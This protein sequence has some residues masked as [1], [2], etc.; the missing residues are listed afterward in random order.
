MDTAAPRIFAML[1][2]ATSMHLKA[3]EREEPFG[4]QMSTGD[5]RT[6]I[7]ADFGGESVK[8]LADMAARA[9]NT[10]LKARLAD[11]LGAGPKRALGACGHRRLCPH[12]QGGQAGTIIFPFRRRW[13]LE[14]GR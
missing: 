7:P 4:P 6:A 12:H 5:R 1:T 3:R 11:M 14:F 9:V 8:L 10:V 13:R 2:A